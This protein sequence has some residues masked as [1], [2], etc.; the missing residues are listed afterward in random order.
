MTRMTLIFLALSATTATTAH[1]DDLSDDMQRYANLVSPLRKNMSSAIQPKLTIEGCNA[2]VAKGRE[3]GVATIEAW[4]TTCREFA[5]WYRVAEAERALTDAQDWIY[6]T[7]QIDTSTRN[8]DNGPKLV[9]ASVT[10]GKE[11]DRLFAAGMSPELE[12]EVGMRPIT[13][14]LGAAKQ[15]I[16]EPL[17]GLAKTYAKDAVAALA[18]KRAH[19]AAPYKAVGIKGERLA[20][21]VDHVDYAMFAS[22]GR[23]L[24]TPKQLKTASIIFELLGDQSSIWT[25]RRYEFKGDKLISTTE[26]EYFLKPG[27]A[28]FK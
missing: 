28:A 25:V 21:L 17:A 9:E 10:C 14:K 6:L 16:C 24:T 3:A 13:V 5:T 26:K 27:A 15:Q 18:A 23:E 1:A 19:A 7:S 12:I 4:A 20:L 8:I 22:G 2:V 11:L